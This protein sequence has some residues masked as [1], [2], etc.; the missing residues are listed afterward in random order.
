MFLNLILKRD[1]SDFR[2]KLKNTRTLTVEYKINLPW[3]RFLSHFY[4]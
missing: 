2:V 4:W 3:G 1:Y